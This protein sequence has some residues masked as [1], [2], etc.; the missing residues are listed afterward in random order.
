LAVR[1]A[2]L[3][4]GADFIPRVRVSN[5]PRLQ[6][7]AWPMTSGR[8]IGRGDFVY[9]DVIGWA[10]GYGF[11]N[12]R[13][14]V[15][16]TPTDEQR[17]C[18]NHAVEATD[19]MI[20]LLKPGAKLGFVMTMSRERQIVAFGH[21]IGLEICENPWLTLAPNK[22][23][24]ESN[25]VLCVEPQVIDRKFGGMCIEDTVLITETGVEVLNR[26]PRVF[27]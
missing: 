21:G 16:G 15:V 1:S 8:K 23:A 4:A 6:A 20:R 22:T 7:L 5:G 2:G 19:W 9:L 27:W 24:I 17:D 10:G 12:S 14:K 3:K 13:I 11:D 18:L 26:C 25:M